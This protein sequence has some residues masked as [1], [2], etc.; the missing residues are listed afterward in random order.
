VLK[1]PPGLGGVFA[2]DLLSQRSEELPCLLFPPGLVEG[3][4]QV[5]PEPVALFAGVYDA[6]KPRQRA[7]QLPRVARSVLDV[8]FSS[9]AP[10]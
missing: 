5:K 8:G 4:P 2:K 9:N 3:D 10:R 6:L 1:V 7:R